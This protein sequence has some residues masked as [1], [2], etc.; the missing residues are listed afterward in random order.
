[1][2]MGKD[3]SF[4]IK[5]SWEEEVG[6][7]ERE[8]PWNYLHWFIRN[9]HS[10]GFWEGETFWKMRSCDSSRGQHIWA[11]HS[12]QARGGRRSSSLNWEHTCLQSS[13]SGTPT[14]FLKDRVLCRCRNSEEAKQKRMEKGSCDDLTL[15]TP[16][17]VSLPVPRQP[18][19]AL[20]S[21]LLLRGAILSSLT[22]SGVFPSGRPILPTPGLPHLAAPLPAAAKPKHS[23]PHAVPS[24]PC[25]GPG[26]REK[27]GT[28]ATRRTCGRA[29]GLQ[30]RGSFWWVTCRSMV[31]CCLGRQEPAFPSHFWHHKTLIVYMVLVTLIWCFTRPNPSGILLHR[32]YS[33]HP[34]CSVWGNL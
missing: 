2:W 12:Y 11:K 33:L 15:W 3:L 34:S 13:M 9:S 27:A 18:D 25:T 21:W 19:L 17:A 28:Y 22:L 29:D 24:P 20:L 32:A 23:S 14:L 1:M 16:S 30:R 7:H 31:G 26:S 5:A 10:I 8:K 4:C 6:G